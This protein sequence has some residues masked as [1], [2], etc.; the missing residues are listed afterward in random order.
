MTLRNKTSNKILSSNIIEVKSLRES[1]QGLIL[2][3]NNKGLFLE[4]RFGIHT[5]LMSH[6]IDV[7][8]LDKKNKVV[9]IKEN[10]KPFRIFIWNPKFDRV[11]ELPQG[12]INKSK[13]KLFDKIIFMQ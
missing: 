7:L 1:T 13:T 10:L 6:A 4:T 11:I 12:N 9:K 3:K 8:I 5:F 2:K